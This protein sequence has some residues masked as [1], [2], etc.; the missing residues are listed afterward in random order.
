VLAAKLENLDLPLWDGIMARLAAMPADLRVSLCLDADQSF[1]WTLLCREIG[2]VCQ[3]RLRCGVLE[4]LPRELDFFGSAGMLSSTARLRTRPERF[5]FGAELARAFQ[6][7]RVTLDVVNQGFIHGFGTKVT[8][9]FA[10]GG[11]MLQERKRDFVDTFGA[12][13]E[14]ISYST[15]TELGDKLDRFL[16]DDHARREMSEVIGEQIRTRHTLP[17]MF[18]RLI[19]QALAQQR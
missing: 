18:R 9:C 7:T 14:A 8:N 6:Q 11:F 13:G 1:Y 5:A 3:A 19:D 2:E 15:F 4:R 12:A 17:I 10:A 16:G